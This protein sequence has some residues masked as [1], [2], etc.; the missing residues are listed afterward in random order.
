MKRT[1]F[2]VGT[3][4]RYLEFYGGAVDKLLGSTI[5]SVVGVMTLTP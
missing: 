1:R 5:P 2:D 3:L 4:A